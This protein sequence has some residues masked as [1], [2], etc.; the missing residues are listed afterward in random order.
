M[1]IGKSECSLWKDTEGDVHSGLD[2]ERVFLAGHL[3]SYSVA[4]FVS[5]GEWYLFYRVVAKPCA[6][7][8]ALNNCRRGLMLPRRDSVVQWAGSTSSVKVK[9]CRP[10]FP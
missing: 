9:I 7:A 3:T 6:G 8:Q 1:L 5:W 10:F 2:I 4:L